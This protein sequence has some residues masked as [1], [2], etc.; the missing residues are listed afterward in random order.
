MSCGSPWGSTWN[1]FIVTCKLGVLLRITHK[2]LGSVL[3][4]WTN[5]VH[6]VRDW[7]GVVVVVDEVVINSEGREKRQMT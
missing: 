1:D 2:R 4:S 3:I 6:L 7:G 5:G